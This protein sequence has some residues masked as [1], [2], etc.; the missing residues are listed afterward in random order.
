[1]VARQPTKG[2]T[3]PECCLV[4]VC[5]VPQLC[6]LTLCRVVGDKWKGCW[7]TTVDAR[8]RCSP[9]ARSQR[10]ALSLPPPSPAPQQSPTMVISPPSSPAKQS[11]GSALKLASSFAPPSKVFRTFGMPNAVA[12]PFTEYDHEAFAAEGGLKGASLARSL[13]WGGLLMARTSRSVESLPHRPR[14]Q[15]D[16]K[17]S[18]LGRPDRH[19]HQEARRAVRG[20]LLTGAPSLA[21]RSPRTTS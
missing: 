14:D 13:G 9:S 11:R 21:H 10:V 19:H 6:M 17:A 7:V 4:Q 15:S 20:P 2:T 12:H 1:M 5:I 18:T 8:R 3:K 16:A